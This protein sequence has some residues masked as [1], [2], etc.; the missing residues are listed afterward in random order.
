MKL[1]IQNLDLTQKKM[2]EFNSKDHIKSNNV[3]YDKMAQDKTIDDLTTFTSGDYDKALG[4]DGNKNNG[5]ISKEEQ[6]ILDECK[7]AVSTGADFD[8]K[9]C[10][11]VNSIDKTKVAEVNFQEKLKN[12]ILEAELQAAD[13][14]DKLKEFL[15]KQQLTEEE[16]NQKLK[17]NFAVLH[18]ELSEKLKE[19]RKAIIAEIN[20]KIN[21]ESVVVDKSSGTSKVDKLTDT[22]QL[23][24]RAESQEDRTR[25]L[26][27]YTNVVSAYIQACDASKLDATKKCTAPTFYTKSL[28]RE[29]AGASTQIQ[30]DHKEYFG[31]VKEG[32]QSQTK[33]DN[34]PGASL[35]S[36]DAINLILG[37]AN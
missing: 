10:K 3:Q 36:V 15:K 28:T 9:K 7:N 12:E 2:A 30:N 1:Q 13:T 33:T 8:E 23:F 16:I 19:E 21:N 35:F 31:Q 32:T 24:G 20:N 34:G 11:N 18:K 27:H 5:L 17:Q 6:K 4:K 22:T 14:Q 29:L 37:D 25:R 26:L